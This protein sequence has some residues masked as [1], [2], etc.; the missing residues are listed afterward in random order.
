[1]RLRFKP[2]PL[3]WKTCACLWPPSSAIAFSE[4][5][6]K[7]EASLSRGRKSFHCV[8]RTSGPHPALLPR[9]PSVCAQLTP[10]SKPL[11][12]WLGSPCWPTARDRVSGT[13]KDGG[14]QQGF[15]DKM[16]AEIRTSWASHPR[17]R[18]P[19]A[20]QASLSHLPDT[21]VYHLRHL[22]ENQ[23]RG[24]GETRPQLTPGEEFWLSHS[25]AG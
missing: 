13:H 25:G 1:M 5:L 21:E 15:Q 24:A 11:M 6:L 2:D 19:P 16:K 22:W 10:S 7:A 8:H 23:L 20:E 9:S 4:F 18:L 12:L 17:H 14:I 3:K